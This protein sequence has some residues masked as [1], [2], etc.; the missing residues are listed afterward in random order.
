MASIRR[1]WSHVF[2][3]CPSLRVGRLYLGGRSSYGAQVSCGLFEQLPRMSSLQSLVYRGAAPIDYVSPDLWLSSPQ[4]TSVCLHDSGYPATSDLPLSLNLP[5]HSLTNLQINHTCNLSPLT[6]RYIFIQ[7][8]NLETA[9]F[10]IIVN[11]ELPSFLL[12]YSVCFP[13]LVRLRLFSPFHLDLAWFTN[14]EFP[15]LDR[16]E[17]H[18]SDG[19]IHTTPTSSDPSAVF[20]QFSS[21][22]HLNVSSFGPAVSQLLRHTKSLTTL[23]IQSHYLPPVQLTHLVNSLTPDNVQDANQNE[24]AILTPHLERLEFKRLDWALI[25]HGQICTAMMIL[26]KIHDMIKARSDEQVRR[27]GNSLKEVCIDDSGDKKSLPETF[28]ALV[29]K[30]H[31][32][33]AETGVKVTVTK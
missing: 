18:G 12:T 20:D 2:K 1:F 3:S 4:L 6:W 15:V 32:L 17:L 24:R 16:L 19:I 14:F 5:F 31:N 25:T 23:T 21:L 29:D 10:A 28:A 26:D 30:L 33:V 8:N 11:Q 7:C 27:C 9:Q 22:R 13:K